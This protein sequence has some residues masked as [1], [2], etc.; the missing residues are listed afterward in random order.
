MADYLSRVFCRSSSLMAELPDESMD[1]IFTSPPYEKLRRYS[2]SPDDLGNYQG[3]EFVGKLA[4]VLREACRVLKSTGNIFLNFQAPNLNGF[5]SPSEFLI[6]RLAVEEMGLHLAQTH[7]W[8]KPNAMPVPAGYVV[9][10]SVELIWHFAKTADFY[11][12]KDALR[13]P[14]KTQ[15]AD[16]RPWKF[17]PLGK[18]PGNAFFEPVAQDQQRGHPAKMP[19]A[20]AERFV[21]YGSKSG[22]AVLD[23]FCGSGTTLLA[24]QTHGRDFVGYELKVEYAEAARVALGIGGGATASPAG[25]EYKKW[26]TMDEAVM[27]TGLSKPTIYSK[28]CRKEIP[29]SKVGRLNR[30]EREQLDQWMRDG[31]RIQ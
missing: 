31:G 12:D 4:P 22:D 8:I 19:L 3:E 18:D 13:V 16:N 15:G 27:Y 2:D 23:P 24:A 1:L 5:V 17:N 6:P 9:K 10:D 30:F 11:V 28:I 26:L 25:L 20:V 21:L 7:Y 14:S 29:V